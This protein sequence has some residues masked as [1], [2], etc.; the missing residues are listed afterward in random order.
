MK[1]LDRVRWLVLATALGM[2]LAAC[3]GDAETTTTAGAG[4]EA[5]TTA[6]GAEEPTT[7]AGESTTTGEPA[8]ET[9]AMTVLLP[10]DS[11]NMYGFRVAE[12]NGYYTEEGLEVTHQFLDGAGNVMQQLL[13]D[14]GDI[15]N[16]GT[17]NVAEAVEQGHEIRAIGNVN[18]GSVFS[19]TVPEDSDIQTPADL[20][21]R[22]VGISELS[23]GEVPVVR[24]IISNAGLDPDSDVELVPIGEGTALAV[25]ALEEG[26]VDAVGG[27]VNDIVAIEVQGLDLRALDPG[28]L[29]GV[30]ALPLVATQ[31]YIDA[32][33]EAVEGF[34][35]AVA[36]GAEFG[37]TNQEE[38]LDIL[39][40]VTP[41]WFTDETGERIFELVLDL[42]QAPEGLLFHEQTPES[43]EYFFDIIAVELPEGITPGD[44]IA[45]DF[46]EAANDF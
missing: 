1:R 45:D 19:L 20:A 21:G 46:V 34:L 7:T 31:E 16:V 39:R 17:A 24:G 12:A 11:P 13:A 42:W 36:R 44:I 26:Q 18:Y 5:T 28:D 41:E 15:G 37:H 10:V 8:G 33:P 25:R 40:E 9:V 3:G 35:R 14:N 2:I 43:W 30:P 23:G 38:T 4:G 6:G 29:S 27:S 32:N 22:R